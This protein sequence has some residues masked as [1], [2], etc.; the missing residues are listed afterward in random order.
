MRRNIR[1]TWHDRKISLH[2]TRRCHQDSNHSN[3]DSNQRKTKSK[4]LVKTMYLD[5][6]T[7]I[8][9]WSQEICKTTTD[10]SHKLL[11]AIKISLRTTSLS[12]PCL[13]Y[14]SITQNLTSLQRKSFASSPRFK[15]T[16]AIWKKFTWMAKHVAPKKDWTNLTLILLGIAMRKLAPWTS[17]KSC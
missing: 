9:Q 3:L 15:L 8:H 13:S 16:K 14:R 17:S 1:K 11:N 2:S 4:S 12:Q 6:G 5:L 7:M 10:R